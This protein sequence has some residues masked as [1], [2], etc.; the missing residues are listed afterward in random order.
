VAASSDEYPCGQDQCLITQLTFLPHLRAD[1]KSFEETLSDEE[2]TM[3]VAVRLESLRETMPHSQ[4]TI[5]FELQTPCNA[6]LRK[7]PGHFAS[8]STGTGKR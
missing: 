8:E 4:F 2:P 5:F 3:A 7:T 6:F 1:V